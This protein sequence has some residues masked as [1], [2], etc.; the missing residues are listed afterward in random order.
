MKSKLLEIRMIE[1]SF[2]EGLDTERS[3]LLTLTYALL[4]VTSL[5]CVYMNLVFT[6]VFNKDQN[7]AW[8]MGVFIGLFTGM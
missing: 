8:V 1:L 2:W 7:T 5:I 6:L 4:C 3:V